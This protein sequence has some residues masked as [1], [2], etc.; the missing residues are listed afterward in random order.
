MITPNQNRF[1][2]SA[3]PRNAAFGLKPVTGES[4][5]LAE[6]RIKL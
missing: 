6:L 2:P 4:V 1:A 3:H 5:G